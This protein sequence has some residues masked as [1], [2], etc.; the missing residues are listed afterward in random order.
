[1][2]LARMRSRLTTTNAMTSLQGFVR[3]GCRD[4]LCAFFAR[5]WRWPGSQGPLGLAQDGAL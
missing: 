5:E 4:A 3:R 1:M 2:K